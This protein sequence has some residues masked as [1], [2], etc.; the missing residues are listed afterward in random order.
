MEDFIQI[1]AGATIR[2]G[3]T[4][5]AMTDI[6]ILKGDASVSFSGDRVWLKGSKAETVF[7]SFK[8]MKAMLTGEMYQI[9][10]AVISAMN[11]GLFT[12][13][14]TAATPVAG[15]TYTAASGAW[16]Y[17]TPII[18]TGQNASGL[19][20]TIASVVGGTDGA[21]TVNV[22]YITVQNEKGEWG[23][24]IIDSAT[25]TTLSQAIVVTYSYT[26]AASIK[27]TIGETAQEI[28]SKIWEI[29]YTNPSNTKKTRV[30][31]WSANQSNDIA[32][33][34]LDQASDDANTYAFEL[35][36]GLDTTRTSGDQL[37][38]IYTEDI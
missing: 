3:D 2:Y 1:P 6:G 21:L 15:A 17:N 5:G 37:A 19:V 38:E 18:L 28:T 31:L 33:N 23:I 4:I 7:K 24:E 9:D 10:Y 26:P 20:Q 34:F 25:V 11:P 14:P 32:F 12:A 29:E 27:Y 16:A 22:D 13:T 36:G 30:R 8:N 35:E